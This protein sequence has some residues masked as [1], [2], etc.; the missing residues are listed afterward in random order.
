MLNFKE[1]SITPYGAHS[2]PWTPLSPK[3]HFGRRTIVNLRILTAEPVNIQAPA[4]ITREHSFYG[5]QM[6]LK[7]EM[8]L[9]ERKIITEL[10]SHEGHHPTEYSRK[11]PRIPSSPEIPSFPLRVLAQPDGSSDNAVPLIFEVGNLSIGGILLRS[12]N[13]YVMSIQLGQQLNLYLEPRGDMPLQ[14]TME[15]QVCRI[16]E[17]LNPKNGNL[18]RMFGIKFTKISEESRT[19]FMELLKDI[20]ERLKMENG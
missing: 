17:E 7:F 3:K 13:P 6:G 15:G 5:E 8:S 11:F 18:V 1:K 12:E 19:A 4:R 20:L 10:V 2:M 16:L 14:V 9:D